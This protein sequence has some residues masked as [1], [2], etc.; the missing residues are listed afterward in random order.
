MIRLLLLLLVFA[1]AAHAQPVDP[2]DLLRALRESTARLDYDTAE[3]RAREVL[4]RFDAFSPSQLVEAHTTLGIVLHARN[5]ATE[6]RRE[7]EAALSLDPALRL[8]SVLV[9]PKTVELFEEVRATRRAGPSEATQAP[10]VRYVVLP[11]RRA[12]AALRSLAVPGWGQFHK[13]ERRR[14][15]AYAATAGAG[16]LSTVA[17][18]VA[19][20]RARDRYLAATAPLDIA[21]RYRTYNRTHQLRG[22]L[23]LGTAAAW[24]ASV[25]DALIT[26]APRPAGVALAPS[27]APAGLALRV[28]L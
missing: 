23:A 2:A 15:W 28:R 18:H 16:A 9:S 1:G 24:T 4:A 10:A 22:A 17:A 13:D 19:R 25:L 21:A 3:Q 27:T 6:A 14:G 8:D 12:G 20:A 5:E 7:F 11:D 26:G